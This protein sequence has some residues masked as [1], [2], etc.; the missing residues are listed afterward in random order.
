MLAHV[1]LAVITDVPTTKYRL[2]QTACGQRDEQPAQAADD[3]AQQ[4]S[5]GRTE[6]PRHGPGNQCPEDATGT[7]GGEQYPNCRG[8]EMHDPNQEHYGN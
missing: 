5:A 6:V 8:P 3:S 7:S 2:A 4:Q 1:M